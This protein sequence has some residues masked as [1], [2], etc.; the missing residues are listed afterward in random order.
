L[1]W[2][3]RYTPLEDFRL[4]P[5]THVSDFSSFKHYHKNLKHVSMYAPNYDGYGQRQHAGQS[6]PDGA[7]LKNLKSF[8][9]YENYNHTSFNTDEPFDWSGL[10]DMT[11]LR[12]LYIQHSHDTYTRYLNLADIPPSV[13]DLH[14]QPTAYLFN[15][16]FPE[17]TTR[18][19]LSI[20]N[21][22][23]VDK[24]N[25]KN[26]IDITITTLNIISTS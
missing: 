6:L 8:Q 18:H 5:T 17:E 3:L 21:A 12:S 26:N 1:L 11:N 13:V 19:K 7:G 10:K 23:I 16:Q 4:G 15:E 9:W 14:I 24:S 22:Q 2:S 25:Y 20:D